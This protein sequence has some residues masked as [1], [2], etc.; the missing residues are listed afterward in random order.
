MKIKI[1]AD[2]TC[3][4]NADYIARHGI[5]ILPLQVNLN[6][7]DYVDGVDIKPD[8]IFRAVAAGSDLP[9]TSAINME[10]FRR[11]FRDG[12]KDCDAILYFA[13]SSE[14]SSCY[15]NAV[16]AAGDLPVYCIDSRNLST[17]IGLLICE[18][19]DMLEAGCDDPKAV[20]DHV[21]S[22]TGK[23][24][25]SFVIDRLDYLHNGGRCSTVAMLGANVLKLKPCIEVVDG[26]MVVGRK[27][28]GQFTRCLKQYVD[29]RMHDLDTVR[30]KRIFLTHTAVEPQVV[31]A[32]A[33][34][35]RGYDYFGEII[36]SCA[37]STISSH[38]G[39]ST[40]GIL[41]IR[42]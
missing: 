14:F 16:Q 31:Q 13:I 21:T 28:R 26:K 6:G 37:G 17:G 29:D 12:L 19:V 30:P 42:K 8:D 2:S 33:D 1:Y 22:L 39:E 41:Y 15:A 25:A 27:Y 11:A 5:T 9:K 32:L 36:E 7:R 10:T 34:Q 23:V 18:A 24:D 38:C 35:L 40:L 20:V 3:D 4:L